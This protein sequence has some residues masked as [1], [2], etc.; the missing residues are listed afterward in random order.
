MRVLRK[1][2]RKALNWA[3]WM[4]VRNDS[5][6]PCI[7]AHIFLN[8]PSL[9]HVPYV[10]SLCEGLYEEVQCKLVLEYQ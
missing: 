2:R 6:A 5:S 10:V 4:W 3:L 1:G 8:R 9:H 7:Y